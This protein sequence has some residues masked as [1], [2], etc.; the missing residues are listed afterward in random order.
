MNVAKDLDD[1][2]AMVEVV[3]VPTL[4]SICL[5]MIMMMVSSES[6]K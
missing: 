4:K 1:A 3:E 5:M 2:D 6:L